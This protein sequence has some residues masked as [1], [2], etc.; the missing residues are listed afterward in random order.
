MSKINRLDFN[1]NDDIAKLKKRIEYSFYRITKTNSGADDCSQEII[2][3]MLDGKHQHSSI[4][5]AVI[6]FIRSNIN[7]KGFRRRIEGQVGPV[8]D[9]FESGGYDRYIKS[10]SGGDIESRIF[11]NRNRESLRDIINTTSSKRREVLNMYF[12]DEKNMSEIG[13]EL[14]M[15]ESRV[16]QYIKSFKEKLLIISLAKNMKSVAEVVKW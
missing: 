6:D 13:N 12:L 5:Q 8:S 3:R 7:H 1:K 2:S 10:D 14:F 11:D 15:S 4:D 9:S 16:S